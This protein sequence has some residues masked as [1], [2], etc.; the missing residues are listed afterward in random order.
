VLKPNLGCGYVSKQFIST[1]VDALRGVLDHLSSYS[2]ISRVLVAEGAHETARKFDDFGYK[3]LEAEYG[4]ELVDIN[5]ER[6]WQDFEVVDLAGR[7]H[8]ARISRRIL[9]ADW[10]ISVCLPK[11]H[12][13]VVASLGIKNML[14]CLHPR[15]RELM[16]G[17]RQSLWV[18]GTAAAAASRVLRLA[19]PKAAKNARLLL[20]RLQAGT[21]RLRPGQI[22]ER[23]LKD[24]GCREATAVV[25]L[26]RALSENLVRLA[27]V[28]APD[29]T[30]VD[31]FEGLEGE[32][33]TSGQLVELG[34]AIAG[35]DPVAVDAIAAT[36]M[37]FEPARIEYLFRADQ[38]GLGTIERDA[39][40]IFGDDI[41]SVRRAFRPHPDLEHQLAWSQK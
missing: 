6:E 22:D 20:T 27:E 8:R 24:P 31:G 11:T 29:L 34:C 39:M 32:G 14:G 21:M 41:G 3:S 36:V 17:V 10:K 28:A 18:Y 37:G 30:V 38:L 5:K 16:H 15:D 9:N 4:V 2:G 1:R 35:T 23:Y 33:P 13:L 7:S 12:D 26:S 25:P 19:G 40:A